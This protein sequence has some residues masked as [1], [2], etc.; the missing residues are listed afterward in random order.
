MAFLPPESKPSDHWR[1]D[2]HYL[3]LPRCG[4]RVPVIFVPY[5]GAQCTVLYC[6]GNMGA[7]IREQHTGRQL[8]ALIG[9]NMVLLE[10]PG[11]PGSMYID[12]EKH[13]DMFSPTEPATYEAAEAALHWLIEERGID[14]RRL[15]VN[16]LSLGSGVATHL[17]QYCA[18]KNIPLGGLLLTSPIASAF[19]VFLPRIWW[20]LP[21]DIFVNVDKIG[22][23]RCK[24]TIMHGTNDSVVP[25][26]NSYLLAERAPPSLLIPPPRYIEGADHND[27]VSRFRDEW[28][29]H[30]RAFVEVVLK[31]AASED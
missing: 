2:V 13:T 3:T 20:T 28:C 31:A 1:S 19:R 6:H 11:Y 8:G 14:V 21:F 26:A 9:C 16:G 23:I 27:I 7:A 25:I 18:R 17:A 24:I 30:V 12:E 5:E 15:I 29:A 10:Y 22:E 4:M